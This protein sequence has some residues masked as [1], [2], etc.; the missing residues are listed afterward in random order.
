M[1]RAP[2]LLA[3]TLVLSSGAAG[4]Q[5]LPRRDVVTID[6]MTIGPESHDA[7]KRQVKALGRSVFRLRVTPSLG[8]HMRPIGDPARL[9]AATLIQTDEGPALI[10]AEIFVRDAAKVEV[11]VD[12][13]GHPAEVLRADLDKGM[14]LISIPEVLAEGFVALPVAGGALSP[15]D[16]LVAVVHEAKGELVIFRATLGGPGQGALAYY[17]LAS[18]ALQSG[19]PLITHDGRFHGLYTFRPVKKEIGLALV[20]ERVAQFLAPPPPR[21]REEVLQLEDRGPSLRPLR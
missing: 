8:P 5:E 11:V 7:L 15:T 12:G 20:G 4:A 17:T 13:V 9:G 1:R 2:I 19:Y 10:T 3:L 16:R 21:I 18:P 6:D 14:A